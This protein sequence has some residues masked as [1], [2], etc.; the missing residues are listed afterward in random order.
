MDDGETAFITQ[1]DDTLCQ[2][3][4]ADTAAELSVEAVDGRLA[5]WIIIDIFDGTAQLG[6]VE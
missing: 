5:Q 2:V 3:R 4:I 1:F 6:E